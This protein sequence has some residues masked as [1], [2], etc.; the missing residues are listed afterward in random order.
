MKG[1]FVQSSNVLAPFSGWHFAR[2]QVAESY[3]KT[4]SSGVM[5]S[6]TIQAP[7]KSGLTN[8]LI[9]DVIPSASHEKF[10]TVYV[11]LSD[12]LLPVSAAVINGLERVLMGS[13]AIY[14]GFNIFK[15]IFHTRN[16]QVCERGRYLNK[17]KIID[18]NFFLENKEKTFELIKI[19]F[20]KILSYKSV[21]ILIDHS[22]NL[23]KDEADLEFCD[24]FRSLIISNAQDIRPL[25]ASS[26]KEAWRGIFESR[27]SPLYSEGAFVHNLP[28]LGK[29]FMREVV[30]RSG[31]NISMDE[32]LSC[33]EM[34][35]ERPGIFTALIM[36]FG[37]SGSK[38][39]TTYF[40]QQLF[41][42]EE[43]KPMMN[44]SS[45]AA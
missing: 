29:N 7:E 25:Y 44:R 3:L 26:N 14:S 15:G 28:A 6:T 19:Y 38:S 13:T 37:S 30:L 1:T 41:M 42:V 23:M 18:K 2:P 24:Y 11:D 12:P 22:D 34:T 39:I 36:A 21:L 45:W 10:V 40:H 35:G 33:Y 31:L 17:P 32:G 43:K 5:L 8:F 16:P 9:N 4:L 27:H 20:K